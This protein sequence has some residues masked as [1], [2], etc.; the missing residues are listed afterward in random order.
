MQNNLRPINGLLTTKPRCFSADFQRV[1]MSAFSCYLVGS[2]RL[3]PERLSVKHKQALC[4]THF[5]VDVWL[6][7]IILISRCLWT[8]AERAKGESYSC[9]YKS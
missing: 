5:K 9:C 2:E 8:P 4:S 7:A 1:W 3:K 6:Q